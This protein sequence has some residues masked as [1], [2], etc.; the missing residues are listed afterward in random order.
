LEALLPLESAAAGGDA[1]L[2]GL[3]AERPSAAILVKRLGTDLRRGRVRPHTLI[4][5]TGINS[6]LRPR[7]KLVMTTCEARIESAA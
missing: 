2:R 1:L 6:F 4:R 7:D 3:L 5:N